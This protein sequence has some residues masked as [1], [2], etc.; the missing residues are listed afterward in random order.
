MTSAAH[1][2][3]I[4]REQSDMLREATASVT[5]AKREQELIFGAIL[6]GSGNTKGTLVALNPDS[7]LVQFPVPES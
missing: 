6:R 2:I 5:R 1:L 7:M 3:P 4:T